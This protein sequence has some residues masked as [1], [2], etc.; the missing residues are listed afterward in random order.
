[1]KNV[2]YLVGSPDITDAPLQAY[3]DEAIEFLAALSKNMMKSPA[4]RAYPDIS[5]LAFWC[6]KANLQKL[7]ENCPEAEKR[8]GR[9]MCFHVAPGNIPI[10]FAFSY[11]FGLLAGC[12]NIVRISSKPFPQIKP[13]CDAV[14]ETLKRF[15]EIEKR[16][17]FV[18]YPADDETTAEICINAD[19]RLIWGGDDTIAKIRTMP[20][21]PRCIDICFAD[22]YSVCMID[23]KAVMDA[24]ET[25][26][27]RLAENFYN[28]TYLMD[29]NAC[30]SEQ[31]IFWLNDSKETREKFWHVV[32]DYAAIK[33]KLQ[34]AVGIDKYTHMFED[35]LDGK[36]ISK[37]ERQTNLLYKAEISKFD[38][39][40]TNLRGKS[41]YFYE[42]TLGDISEIVPFVTEKFQ[43]VTYFGVDSEKI[44]GFVISNR[45]RGIDRIVPIGK[46]MDIDIM[47]D[48]FDLVR[49]LSRYVDKE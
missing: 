13:V 12:S 18:R 33:Y 9:G 32:Y 22:R 20:S 29:Q 16:T 30:S 28:D 1:M 38:G 19:A 27:S 34:A 23:G 10:N 4:L 45:L 40:I 43:T 31:L 44:R 7:R 24:D 37:I 39:D 11:M 2:E 35:I 42:Y 21:K 6:R 26:M 14:I 41:G 8:L 36:P 48:G 5:A 15:P 17:A 3:G 25:A 47:W 46:A 49:M